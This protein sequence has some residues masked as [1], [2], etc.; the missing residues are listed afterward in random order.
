MGSDQDKDSSFDFGSSPETSICLD[1]NL[2]CEVSDCESVV[3]FSD[4]SGSGGEDNS[5]EE[6]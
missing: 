4:D 1:D 2:L 6:M 3:S 5:S